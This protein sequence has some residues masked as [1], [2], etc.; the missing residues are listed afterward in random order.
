MSNTMRMNLLKAG[1]IT[2]SALFSLVCFGQKGGLSAYLVI[3]DTDAENQQA[4][5]N[6]RPVDVSIHTNNDIVDKMTVTFQDTTAQQVI[7]EYNQMIELF[8]KDK[9]YMDFNQN[10]VLL[11]DEDIARNITKSKGY[12][13]HFN[14]YD[15][16]RNPPLMDALLDK[17]SDYFTAE[18]L[19]RLKELARKAAD[20]PEDK[21]VAFRI[22]MIEEIRTMGLSLS[23]DGKPDAGK[24]FQFMATFMGGLKDLSDGDVWFKI[25]K[26][27]KRYQLVL[28]YDAA[29]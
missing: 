6:G 8:R 12:E 24:I 5:F 21:K 29:Q 28:G 17:V 1:L 22:E 10:E 19:T 13:A 20:T 2:L 18:Q 9:N 15:P 23:K 26:Y 14:Y 11:E 25:Q 3:P 16:D 7:A 4:T 27:E